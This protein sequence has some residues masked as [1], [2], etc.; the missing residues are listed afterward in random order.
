MPCT[1]VD[2]AQAAHA[3]AAAGV[4]VNAFVVRTAMRDHTAHFPD[5]GLAGNT[6]RKEI[7]GYATHNLGKGTYDNNLTRFAYLVSQYP[8]FNHTFILR[9]IRSLRQQGFDIEV[10]SIRDCDRPAQRLTADEREELARTWYVKRLGLGGLLLQAAMVALTRPGGFLGGLALAIRLGG[11]DVVRQLRYGFYFLEAVTA[12]R[13]LHRQGIS[14]FHVHF[15]STVALLMT[16]IYPLTMSMTIHGPDEFN[17][18]VGFHMAEKVSACRLVTAISFFCRSQIMR[19]C[20]PADWDKIA[21]SRLG[22]D[23]S[24]FSPR[25]VR[26]Q[27]Q[28]FEL[29]CVGRLAPAKAQLLL[30]RACKGLAEDGRQFRLRIVGEGPDRAGLTAEIAQLG[31]EEKV[32]LTGALNQDEVRALYRECDLFILGSFAE[33]VPVVLM[34]AMAMEI[35]CVSTYIAG[36][37]ELIADGLEGLLVPA[38]DD[39]ALQGAIGRLMDDPQLREQLGREG[40]K[41]VMAS[42]DL[43]R[44]V[45]NLGELFQRRLAQK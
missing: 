14:H 18:P 11:G 31:L 26:G 9:E 33:G 44:N 41:R 32:F 39:K 10:V 36:I 30:V 8:A 21:V 45:R 5:G 29:L 23:P 16:R 25:P 2:D 20:R 42:Y 17:D 28:Q 27:P 24:I 22:V 1:E 34:E 3:N 37:P 19:F 7:S 13:R 12:A 4:D 40:R 15:S 38:S 35:P 43:T 6:V